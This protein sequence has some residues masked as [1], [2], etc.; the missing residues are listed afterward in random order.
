MENKSIFLP[1]TILLIGLGGIY[2]VFKRRLGEGIIQNNGEEEA[3]GNEEN[4]NWPNA[5]VAT[6][7]PRRDTKW[8]IIGVYDTEQSRVTLNDTIAI[9]KFF[10][11]KENL[12][13][14][15]DVIKSATQMQ[16]TDYPIV[17]QREV[18]PEIESSAYPKIYLTKEMGRDFIETF[19]YAVGNMNDQKI[20]ELKQ[21]ILR[22]FGR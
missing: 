3:A 20:E 22:F 9:L 19:A 4:S 2:L 10:V 1:L 15:A 16:N 7:I 14:G 11:R 5:T 8:R 18:F 6:V 17:V 13:I 12:P 21:G